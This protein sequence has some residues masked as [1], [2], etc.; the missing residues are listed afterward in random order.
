[1]ICLYF[2]QNVKFIKRNLS[3]EFNN[4]CQWFIDDKF[5]IHSGED[6]TKSILF[7]EGNEPNLSLAY[8]SGEAMTRMIL[9]EFHGKKK[10]LYRQNRFSF[11][12]IHK[13]QDCRGRGE[14]FH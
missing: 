2:H 1:M 11:M 8:M 14:V 7:K 3:S 6:K 12:S 10:L 13:S 9:K 4:L 5:S